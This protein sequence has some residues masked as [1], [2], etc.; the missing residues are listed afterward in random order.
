MNISKKLNIWQQHKL[1]TEKQK[2]AIMEFE[3]KAKKPAL[4]YA[5]VFI[6]IFC[7]GLGVVSVI[8]SNWG[9]IPP[10]AKLGADFAILSA[11]IYGI[12]K[13]QR[14]LIKEGLLC[15]YAIMAMASIG[16]VAQI[17][18][19]VPHG[20]QAFL[21][22]SAIVSPLVFISKKPLIAFVW[23]P[24]LLVSG[25]DT[26]YESIECF[27]RFMVYLEHNF[28]KV[29]VAA[30]LVL[31]GFVYHF[32]AKGKQTKQLAYASK[33]WLVIFGASYVIML[34]FNSSDLF[35]KYREIYLGSFSSMAIWFV[36][37]GVV[38]LFHYLKEKEILY[39]L[40][41]LIGFSF[42]HDILPLAGIYSFKIWGA[43]LSLSM[44]VIL[45]AYAHRAGR[46]KL[47]NFAS[48]LIALRIFIIYIQVFGS[49]LNTGLGLI[50]SGLVFLVITYIWHKS[51]SK[52]KGVKKK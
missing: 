52:I 3:T 24:T 33:W 40:L 29:P 32:F 45:V 21:F 25:F 39:F 30:A 27:R 22:W 14:P 47:L 35:Y 16:L 49:L 1:I 34:D 11:I 6:S 37:A 43:L 4:L 46:S 2:D 48:F 51:C 19:L 18:H 9:I 44:L 26:L 50:T 15:L 5:I 7:I 38:S 23:L 13:A 36:L 8:A 17:Y 28:T 20:M 41:T 31:G 42:I 10:S 12:I